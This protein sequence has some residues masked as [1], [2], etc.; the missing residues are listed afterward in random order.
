MVFPDP[1]QKIIALLVIIIIHF[2][3]FG[4]PFFKLLISSSIS[5]TVFFFHRRHRSSQPYQSTPSVASSIHLYSLYSSFSL[6]HFSLCLSFYLPLLHSV[7]VSLS[8]FASYS[9]IGIVYVSS[10]L[11]LI[12]F[13]FTYPLFPALY[14]L[15]FFIGGRRSHRIDQLFPAHP[16]RLVT[17]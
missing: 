3:L 17:S 8:S 7:F 12:E 4:N 6:R 2:L 5:I 13:H 11:A 14:I 16:A 15:H 9:A 10:T 1:M